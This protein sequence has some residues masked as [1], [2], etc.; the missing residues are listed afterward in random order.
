MSK[1]KIEK[2]IEKRKKKKKKKR[3][4]GGYSK[5]KTEKNEQFLKKNGEEIFESSKIFEKNELWNEYQKV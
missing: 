2:K 1:K 5:E 3:K 4:N